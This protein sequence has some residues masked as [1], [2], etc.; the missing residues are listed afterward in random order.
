[1]R[2]DDS[3]TW[4]T[5]GNVWQRNTTDIRFWHKADIPEMFDH[6]RFQG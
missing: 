2:G 5:V 4:R 3:G 6:V 1:M